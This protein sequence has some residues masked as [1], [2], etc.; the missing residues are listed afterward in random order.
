MPRVYQR[1]RRVTEEERLSL[2][3][4]EGRLLGGG[5]IVAGLEGG[6]KVSR[7]FQTEGGA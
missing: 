7:A 3:R 5:A 1:V 6:R 2:T 4:N